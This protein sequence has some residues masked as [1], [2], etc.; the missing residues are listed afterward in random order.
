MV[1]DKIYEYF[2]RNPWL[3]VLFI[4]N[5]EFIALDLESAEWREGYRYVDFKGILF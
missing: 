5:D 4:F 2:E 1:Q 3:K